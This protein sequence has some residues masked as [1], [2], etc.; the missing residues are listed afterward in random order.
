M[1]QF[2]REIVEPLTAVKGPRALPGVARPPVDI[3]RTFALVIP[4]EGDLPLRSVYLNHLSAFLD[5]AFRE[6]DFR[7]GASDARR[8]ATALLK[9]DYQ[10]RSEAFYA[11]D[12]ID[13]GIVNVS[14][15]ATLEDIPSTR[16]PGRNVREV[17]EDALDQRISALV[18]HFNLPGPDNWAT[19]TLVT[20]IVN[21][22][23]VDK[24]PALWNGE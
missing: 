4:R 20:N 8:V 18:K 19:D 2:E 11:P 16:E 12:A 22:I 6:Y 24:L 5:R 1:V 10:H 23:V 15:Y 3:L 9:I 7:R 21:G 14:R 17:F 13:G